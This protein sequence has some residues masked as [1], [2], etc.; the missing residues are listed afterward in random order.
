MYKKQ[1]T[2]QRIVC[3]A[4]LIAS[5]LVFVYSLGIMTDLYDALYSTIRNPKNL[6][7]TTVTGSRVYY[8]MQDFN[9]MFTNMSIV[10][11]LVTL[12]LFVTNTHCRRK[13]YIGNFIATVLSTAANIAI[14]VWA[15]PQIMA[16][17]AQFL[18][19]NFEELKE[20]AEGMN[21]LYTESTLWFDISYAVFGILLLLSVLL[22]VNLV[23]K[24]ILMKEEKRLI[25]SRKDVVA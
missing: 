9:R 17:K 7:R 10:L 5:A 15:I 21:T 3:F 25:G 18:Q 19:I 13:Y 12:T 8:D 14:T 22:I 16:F 11:I 4:L 24:V 6:D 20:H 23:L 2:F 1:M